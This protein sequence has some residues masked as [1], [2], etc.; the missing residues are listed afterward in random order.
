MKQM[1]KIRLISRAYRQGSVGEA[2][3][4]VRVGVRQVPRPVAQPR[5]PPVFSRQRPEA[6]LAGQA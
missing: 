2:M 5:E 6:D 1:E 3:L 4:R